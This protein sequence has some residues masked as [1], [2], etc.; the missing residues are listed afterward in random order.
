MFI[1]TFTS[2]KQ[3]TKNKEKK[4]F[5]KR[6]ADAV[7]KKWGKKGER[8]LREYDGGYDFNKVIKQHYIIL[9]CQ[10][11]FLEWWKGN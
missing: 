2:R 6:N 9:T 7:G 8:R 10:I 3:R 1:M 5:L 11:A 4:A